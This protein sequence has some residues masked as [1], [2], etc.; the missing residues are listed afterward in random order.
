MRT[1][2]LAIVS[3]LST[4]YID[5]GLSLPLFLSLYIYILYIYIF[6]SL[7]VVPALVPS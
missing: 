1:S 4:L 3:L 5:R 7:D 2:L 6:L